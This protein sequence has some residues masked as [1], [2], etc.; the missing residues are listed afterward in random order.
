MAESAKLDCSGTTFTSPNNLMTSRSAIFNFLAT[1]FNATS[2]M[3]KIIGE[4]TGTRK[5]SSF[6]S[7]SRKVFAY[8]GVEIIGCAEFIETMPKVSNDV[9]DSANGRAKFCPLQSEEEKIVDFFHVN[10]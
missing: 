10:Y 8:E 5:C 7:R 9:L 2:R 6:F 4:T 3:K 1:W